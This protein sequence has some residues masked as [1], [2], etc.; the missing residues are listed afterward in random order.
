MPTWPNDKI[1]LIL[2]QCDWKCPENAIPSAAGTSHWCSKWL[3]TEVPFHPHH[4]PG[5]TALHQ[6]QGQAPL[7]WLWLLWAVCAGGGEAGC[8]WVCR[9]EISTQL[10]WEFCMATCAAVPLAQM[11]SSFWVSQLESSFFLWYKA[12]PATLWDQSLCEGL[13]CI[14]Y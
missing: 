9:W 11:K 4:H 8:V 3:L 7:N 10:W 14:L 12:M 1:H 13:K 6:R 2:S 5:Q